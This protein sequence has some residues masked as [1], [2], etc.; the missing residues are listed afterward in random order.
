MST[1]DMHPVFHEV[2]QAVELYVNMH[3]E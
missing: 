1:K 3:I 2:T